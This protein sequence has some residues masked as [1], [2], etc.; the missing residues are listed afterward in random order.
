MNK[1]L[2]NRLHITIK[3]PKNAQ[4]RFYLDLDVSIPNT[5]VTA[6]FGPSGSGKTTLLRYIAGLNNEIQ[7]E[8]RFRGDIWQ[9]QRRTLASHKRPIGYVFQEANL[10]PH[11]TAQQNLDFAIK[12]ADK[13]QSVIAYDEVIQLLNIEDILTRYP[14]QLSGGESQRVA[15][16]R[17]LLIQPK[18]LL[19]DEPLAA[20]DEGLKQEILPYLEKV[21]YQANIPII[22]VSHA[23][24]E[25]I[26][27]SDHMLVLEKGKV[28]EQGETSTLLGQLDSS[29]STL[30]DASVVIAG[31]VTKQSIEWG[32]SWVEVHDQSIIVKT[33]NEQIGD[34]LRLRIQSKD[35]SL[36]LSKQ[37]DSSIL[38]RLSA[39]IDDLCVDPKD[40]SMVLVRLLIGEVPIM[41]RVT[42][43]SAHNLSLAKGKS[44][45]AQIKSVA[46][47]R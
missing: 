43:L 5:G 24:D 33:A 37:E 45:I 36:S 9:N 18:L 47:L 19:M 1:L 14:S 8:L 23:L 25:V 34:T 39:F 46:L 12:R 30:Q 40:A 11:L 10:F 41:A 4:S 17:A 2:N 44:V 6:L 38:N 31:K 26:R 16:A 15:I 32:L 13:T 42:A 20:L 22:Y 27:L 7:G 3:P 29:F 35:V 21:C 28:I